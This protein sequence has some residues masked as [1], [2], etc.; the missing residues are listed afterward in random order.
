VKTVATIRPL[1]RVLLLGALAF[2]PV[3]LQIHA[4]GIQSATQSLLD[5]AHALEVRG[6]LD[7]ASQTWQ[8]VLLADPQNAE[9]LGGLARAAKFNGN[10]ALAS[11]YLDRL[12]AINPN[13]PN[14]TRVENMGSQQNQSAALKQAGKLAQAG[15]YAQ[16]MSLYR[17][18]FGTNPPAGDWALAY[19]E[20]ESATDDGRAHAIA[21]LRALIEKFPSDSRYQVTLGRILTYNPKTREEGRRLLEKHPNDPQAAAA[22]RQSLVWDA[23]NPASAADIRAYLARHND[24]QLATALRNQPK[25]SA[26]RGATAAPQTPEEIAAAAEARARSVQEQEAYNALNAKRIDDAELR[27]KAILASNPDNARALAGMGYV[28]M[29]QSN[30][31]GAISFLEQA[32]QNG[33]TDAGINTALETARFY[34][35]MGEGSTALNENDL[36]TAEKQYQAAL[37]MRPN[38]A[39]ALE[40]LG[41]TLLKAQQPEAAIEVF[42]RYVKAK[43]SA[44]AAWRGLF[45]A[46]YGAGNAPQALMTERRIPSAVRSQLMRDPEFLR[47]LASAYS[48]VGRDADAQRVLHSALDLPFPPGARGLKVETQLQ[49][50]SLLQQ[51]NRL[52]QAGALFRYSPPT[53]RTPQPGRVSS[54]FSTQ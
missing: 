48:A 5:K 40:G 36:P 49:Y 43:P 54:A 15:Q 1:A 39:E 52:D 24:A 30:F 20:T 7:M 29:Q 12:R 33:G 14:I 38:S 53:S 47:S 46:Y 4:Q 31:G 51:A 3:S 35:T 18:V 16:A 34:Y 21:G 41:G 32:K 23:S 10:N 27:F 26:A 2:A 45:M 13:D 50:A 28:R 11:S 19:Y 6:R 17:Q 9:A 25:P 44:P 8:Q 42:D 22:L 37:A